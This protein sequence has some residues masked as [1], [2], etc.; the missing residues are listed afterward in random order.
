MNRTI[1]DAAYRYGTTFE[2]VPYA[3]GISGYRFSFHP[4]ESGKYYFLLSLFRRD[5]KLIVESN[6]FSLSFVVFSKKDN[7]N[8]KVFEKQKSELVELFWR[9]YHE[10]KNASY[11][12][13]VVFDFVGR[14][15]EYLEAYRSIYN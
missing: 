12:K 13:S 2:V 10:T 9:K 11:S 1:L 15:N 14:N 5:K 3:L 7:E 8:I 6:N 4:E